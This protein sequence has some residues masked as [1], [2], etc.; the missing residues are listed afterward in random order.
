MSKQNKN[1]SHQEEDLGS[2]G[3]RIQAAL[4]QPEISQL[5]NVLFAVLSNDLRDV[6]LKQ[7]P[8]DTQETIKQILTPPLII[9]QTQE[10]QP[11]PVSQA[12]LAQIWLGLWQEWEEIIVEAAAEEGEY[13]LQEADW[14]PPY[15]DTY[16]FAENLDQVAQKMLPLVEIAFANRFNPDSGFTSALVLAESEIISGIPD[17]MD[18]DDGIYLEKHLTTC[19]LHWEWLRVKNA[20]EDAF[21]FAQSIRQQEEN[22]EHITL[23]DDA[24]A[25]FLSQLSDEEQKCILAGLNANRETALWQK[26]LDNTYSHW[27]DFY[28]TATQQYAPPEIY[29]NNL[30]ATIGQQWQNGLPV[31]ADL[32]AKQDFTASLAVIEETVDALLKSQHR[33]QSWQPE[34]SLLFTIVDGSGNNHGHWQ[35][36]KTLLCYYQQTAAGLGQ[37]ERIQALKIQ[38]IVFDSCFDW[39]VILETFTNI[40]IAVEIHQSL[41]SSWRDYA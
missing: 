18:I 2:V 6:A 16:Q 27:H 14:E 9:A 37:T 20:G 40:P 23:D 11:K 17:W 32:L 19:L 3:S 8:A 15:F 1:Q 25:D 24:I 22:F 12:K 36:E 4:T 33:G 34:T 7:L 31:I 29:L 10:V 30:R 5:L 28:M 38:Q 39:S 35:N 26:P 13:I 21:N 41:F